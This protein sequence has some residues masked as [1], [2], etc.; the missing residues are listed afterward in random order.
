MAEGLCG[1]MQGVE[2]PKKN[3]DNLLIIMTLAINFVS[4]S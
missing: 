4:C 1:K 2:V 3:P